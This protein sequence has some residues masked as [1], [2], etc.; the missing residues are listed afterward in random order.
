MSGLTSA[1][2]NALSGL[3]ITSGQ[4]AIVSRNVTRANDEN[5][6][7][8]QATLLTNSDGSV[9]L[10]S[11][12][13]NSEKKLLDS[14]LLSTGIASGQQILLDSL[15]QLGTTVGDVELDGSIGWGIGQLQE[16]L[17]NYESNPSSS[18][19]AGQAVESAR[20]VAA[21]LNEATKIVQDIRSNAD[22]EMVK[23]VASINELL[24][25]YQKLDAT[26]SGGNS[27]SEESVS[28]MDERDAILKSLAAQIGIRTVARSDGSTAIFTESG[29]TL[30]DRTPRQVT[31]AASATLTAGVAGQSVFA[32][33][34]QI[35]GSSSPMPSINGKLAALAQVRDSVA[36]GYQGQ[37]DEIARGL[38][39]LFAETDQGV[40]ATQPPATGLFAYSGAPALPA[41][42]TISDGLAGE[43]KINPLYDSKLGGNPS[44][45]RDGGANGVTYVYN[46]TNLLGFQSRLSALVSAFDQPVAF[47]A[48]QLPA[49]ATIKGF[50]TAS[51]GWLEGNRSQASDRS[52]TAQ[53][54][55]TRTR[56]ALMRATGVNLD[57]EMATLLNLEKSYQASAKV[58]ATV[59]QMFGDLV[60]IVR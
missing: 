43:I 11:I 4:S 27:T 47:G 9:R 28:A 26:I 3:L 33:G 15:T 37:L 58:L 5:Y 7:R 12:A 19:F 53:T 41:P 30:F 16:A 21:S 17:K 20:S 36:T 42:A 32:D 1:L 2:S 39:G 18:L 10:S 6:V 46:I 24:G 25:R 54:T 35:L 44:L 14:L 40:P 45:L 52:A 13:R 8:K 29:V 38:I 48:A 57:E 59:D 49:T 34:V 31:F 50:A 22:G 55:E 51:A 23:S 56:D 60:Q